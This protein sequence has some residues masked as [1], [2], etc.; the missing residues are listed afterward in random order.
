VHLVVTALTT[1]PRMAVVV[2]LRLSTE[3]VVMEVAVVVI[4]VR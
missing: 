4:K 1:Q 3:V 2:V